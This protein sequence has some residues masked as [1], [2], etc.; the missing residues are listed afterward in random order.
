[1]AAIDF[2]KGDKGD[3][4]A[5]GKTGSQGLT[6]LTGPIGEK[7]DTGASGFI[8]WFSHKEPFI[9]F[10]FFIIMTLLLFGTVISANITQRQL[11]ETRTSVRCL[12]L[13][14]NNPTEVLNNNRDL[15]LSAYNACI[16]AG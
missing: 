10:I 8:T 1:M 4:G 5:R 16:K 13:V 6:G 11:H 14:L 9:T 15:V 7:G 12:V 2:T 3:T